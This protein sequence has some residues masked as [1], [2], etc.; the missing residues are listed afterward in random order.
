LE[1]YGESGRRA[2]GGE[3]SLAAGGYTEVKAEGTLKCYGE[4]GRREVRCR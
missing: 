4:N 2:R 3:Q 1:C